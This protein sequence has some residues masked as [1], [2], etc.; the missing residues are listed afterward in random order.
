MKKIFSIAA[1][2]LCIA[3]VI[4]PAQAEPSKQQ[5]K[6]AEKEAKAAVKDEK[7]QGWVFGGVGTFEGA[8]TRYLLE[9]KDFGGD[10]KIETAQYD[11]ASG[12]WEGEEGLITEK[13]SSFAQQQ[14]AL[15]EKEIAAHLGNT[16]VNNVDLAMRSDY[17]FNGDVKLIFYAYKKLANGRYDLKGYFA[18]DM[19]AARVQREKAVL[20]YDNDMSDQIKNRVHHDE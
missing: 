2:A 3:A 15:L 4:A 10:K 8:Y 12:L 19:D 1:A 16:R 6:A 11:N 18:I 9:S 13:Q 20:Q 14:K 7:K 17:L 5:V